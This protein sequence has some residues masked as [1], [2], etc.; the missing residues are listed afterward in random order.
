M[1]K[2]GIKDLAI[3]G[4]P[5]AFQNPLHVNRPNFG[6]RETFVDRLD[7]MLEN[8]RFTNDG[9]LVQELE[10]RLAE[11]FAVKH[12]VATSSGTGALGLIARALRLT[13]E[14]IVPSFTFIA[15]PNSLA[16]QGLKPVFCDIDRETL[17]IDPIQCEKLI[18]D[19]TTAILG[20][21][22]WGKPCDTANLSQI[23]SRHGLRL[24]FDAAH[25][26]GCTHEGRRL[27][28]FGDAE[29]FSFH[30][31][32]VFH[33]LEGGAVTTN[34]D[35]IAEQVTLMRNFGFADYDKTALLGTNAKMCEACAAVGLANLESV[36]TFF[37]ENRRTHELYREGLE[38]VAGLTLRACA[39]R[40]THSHHFVVTE[41]SEG[42]AGLSR[43]EMI[44][45][46]HAEN[47]L[48]RRYF[49]PGSHRLEPYASIAPD[50][51]GRLPNT[52]WAAR[53]ALILPAGGGLTSG[54]VERVCEIIRL[55]AH[56]AD[57]VRSRLADQGATVSVR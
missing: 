16:W 8:R 11:Y 51:G 24:F 32:K 38:G 49:Y 13:G 43:D 2:S 44:R 55:V 25:A 1:F 21:H 37:E 5:P 53:R 47:I 31:T 52:N 6:N 48:A 17:N 57:P 54:E 39:G 12:C 36:D 30:A 46:L 15:T 20:V 42:E 7:G 56:N 22:L 33:T 18:T 14:V 9:P 29:A 45:L 28:G 23:A 40:E 10:S 19:R 27:A 26:F 3:F 50:V 4:G 41:L 34:D 35:A